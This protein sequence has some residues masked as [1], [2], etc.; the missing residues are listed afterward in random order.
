[1]GGDPV[2]YGISTHPRTFG[3]SRCTVLLRRLEAALRNYGARNE[4]RLELQELGWSMEEVDEYER[5]VRQRIRDEREA[6]AKTVSKP[7]Q[8]RSSA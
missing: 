8:Q 7:I 1:L 2:T 3:R 6:A 4:I 5:G